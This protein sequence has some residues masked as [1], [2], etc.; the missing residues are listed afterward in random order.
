MSIRLKCDEYI[1]SNSEVIVMGDINDG[2]GMD[3]YENKFSTS[4]VEIL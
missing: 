1:E 2:I 4:A 3:F